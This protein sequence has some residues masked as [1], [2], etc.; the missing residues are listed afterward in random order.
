MESFG[1]NN[2]TSDKWSRKYAEYSLEMAHNID[3]NEP[4]DSNDIIISS[5]EDIRL[6]YQS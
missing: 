2:M 1:E 3:V 4:T 5:R 6:H